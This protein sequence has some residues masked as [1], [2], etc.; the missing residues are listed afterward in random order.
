MAV[1]LLLVQLARQILAVVAAV[2]LEP[3][4]LLA[5]QAAQA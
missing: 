5:A 2:G 3:V 1:L 4:E